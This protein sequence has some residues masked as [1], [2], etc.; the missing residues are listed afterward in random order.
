MSLDWGTKRKMMYT[1][2]LLLIIGIAGTIFLWPYFN[3]EPTCFDGKQNGIESGIDCGGSCHKVCSAE[4]YRL[5]TLWSRAFEVVP[6]K[7][8]FMAYVENQNR[9]AGI[10]KINYEFRAYDEKNIFLARRE[11]STFVSSNDRT[12]IFEAGID[13]GN[14]KPERVDFTFTS[15]P[16]WSKITR[17][18]RNS[19]AISV[20]D[21]VL[22]NPFI[23]PKLEANV[24][25]RTIKEINDLSVYVILYDK[26][27]N[28]S[29]VSKT[30]I[31]KLPKNGEV[32]I[33]F[34]WPVPLLEEPTR[35]DI[36]PQV[37][38]FDLGI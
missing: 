17:E 33:V 27:N 37:N 24:I 3:R 36:F 26:N 38:I 14:R 32:P 6:G 18:Q 19:L 12:A 15:V 22:S 34:T 29:N 30:F 2:V 5:V 4:A 35:I 28:V 7:Y 8:N 31:E 11:G 13:T 20:E 1:S 10:R 9:E 21:K 16:V 23:S 25:N